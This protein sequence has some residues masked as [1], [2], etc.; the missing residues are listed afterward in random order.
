MFTEVSTAGN[1]TGGSMREIKHLQLSN[2][3]AGQKH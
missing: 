3:I 2:L 1:G